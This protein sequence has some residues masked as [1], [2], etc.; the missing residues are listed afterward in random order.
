MLLFYYTNNY[1]VV[2][3]W[4]R[5][6]ALVYENGSKQTTRKIP[7][8]VNIFYLDWL[9][10]NERIRPDG[11]NRNDPESCLKAV[12]RLISGYFPDKGEQNKILSEMEAACDENILPEEEFDWLQ[13]DVRATFW[14]WAY[15]YKAGSYQLGID[16]PSDSAPGDNWYS[17][18]KLSVSPSSHPERLN[19]IIS[20]FD[21]I[22]VITPPVNHLKKKIMEK[23]K[24]QWAM[25]YK[26]PA[27]LKWLPDEENAVIWAWDSLHKIQE[28]KNIT[29]GFRLGLPRPG[30]TTW[31]TPLNHSER[32]IALRAA[33]DLWDDAPDTK[34]LF[35]LNLN[36]AWNQHK[37]RRART[38]KK[39]LN[40]YLKNE[41][42]RRL[43]F[44]AEHDGI[45][46]SDMM[47]K[48]IND[49]YKKEFG[50][51]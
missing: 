45:R 25:I 22:I 16:L 46:I 8:R 20:L 5:N 49:Y 43:D 21:G 37:L 33:L 15:L 29:S 11:V 19:T 24:E 17:Y 48:L 35:L 23:L 18:L 51:K 42:K 6:M 40:T 12:K 7:H 32:N 4:D 9:H 38:D 13:Q 36:K 3:D 1:C 10:I 26:K 39:A 2:Y 28:E 44:M 27:P 14:L 50:E 34:Q 30:L 41:T 47:D 31:F